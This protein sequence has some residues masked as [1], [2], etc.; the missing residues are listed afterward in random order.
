ME[1]PTSPRSNAAMKKLMMQQQQQQ[2][3]PP[4]PPHHHLAQNKR[5]WMSQKYHAGLSW[6]QRKRQERQQ[7]A[8]EAQVEEQRRILYQAQHGHSLENNNNNHNNNNNALLSVKTQTSASGSGL[9][10]EHVFYDHEDIEDTNSDDDEDVVPQ[11]RLVEEPPEAPSFIL[12]RQQMQLLLEQALPPSIAYSK[13]K[14]IYCLARD[15][16]DFGEFLRKCHGKVHTLLV[17]QTTTD[18]VFGG[19]AESPWVPHADG[20]YGLGQACLFKVHKNENNNNNKNTT[21]ATNKGDDNTTSD[22]NDT[23]DSSTIS[24]YKWTGANRYIQVCDLT[25]RMI[26]LGGG[27]DSFGLCL[28]Q[29]FSVGST[30]SCDTFRNEPLCNQ[31]NFQVLNVEV[32]G[33]LLGQF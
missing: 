33:F 31:E 2:Q 20:F 11:V 1:S 28:E 27:G 17:V 4:P 7:A 29:D 22:D 19:Y 26:C 3:A 18:Q 23:D 9:Q 30:G 32:Y 15:G 25:N 13:W 24:V 14:R 8:L 12:E 6:I 16:D 5:E 21:D 10:V